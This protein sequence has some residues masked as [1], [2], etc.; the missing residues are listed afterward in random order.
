MN[1]SPL[2]ETEGVTTMHRLTIE[3]TDRA[4]TISEHPDGAD[5]KCTLERYVEHVNCRTETIQVHS[6]FSSWQLVTLDDSRVHATATIEH[7]DAAAAPH[8]DDSAALKVVRD[9]AL[10]V[11]TGIAVVDSY[12]RAAVQRQWDKLAGA[13]RHFH[14]AS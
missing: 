9:S 4:T 13:A 6:D 12:E 14:H 8:G 1:R 3:R 7:F 5:A 11:D 10:A 2:D